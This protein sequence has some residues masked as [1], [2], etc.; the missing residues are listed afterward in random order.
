MFTLSALLLTLSLVF[1]APV[2]APVPA[3]VDAVQ[4]PVE[5]A[6]EAYGEA[7]EGSVHPLEV[8][9]WTAIDNAG[10]TAPVSDNTYMLTYMGTWSQVTGILP[11][12]WFAITSTTGDNTHYFA[13][14]LTTQA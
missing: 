9:A 8:D 2:Q 7:T 13:W 10:I 14:E 11:L 1:G 6:T 4:A 12:G 5:A 3:P